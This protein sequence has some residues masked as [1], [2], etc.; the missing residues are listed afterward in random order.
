MAREVLI[1]ESDK[2][3]QNELKRIFEPAGYHLFF[4]SNDE[5]ALVRGRL[6]KPDLVIGG[7]GLCERMK[8]EEGLA[9]IP[10][11]LL[12]DPFEELSEPERRFLKPEGVIT[13]PF[14]EE[15]VQHLIG[16]LS[17]KIDQEGFSLEESWESDE[18]IIE[19]VDV[20]EEPE[21]KMSIEDLA[22]QT[23]EEPLGEMPAI[24]TW[25][26]SQK[27]AQETPKEFEMVLE[28]GGRQ[29]EETSEPIGRAAGLQGPEEI[30]LFQRI[31]MEEVM[32][33]VEQ[34]RP[35]LEKELGMEG[36]HTRP[37][38]PTPST[39]LPDP[40]SLLQEFETTLQAEEAVSSF[41]YREEQQE[42]LAP[43]PAETVELASSELQELGEDEFPEAF[44]EE[45]TDELEKL[46]EV[47]E[48][49]VVAEEE[50]GALEEFEQEF[51]EEFQEEFEEEFEEKFEEETK[52][53]ILPPQ[54]RFEEALEREFTLLQEISPTSEEFPSAE[55]LTPVEPFEEALIQAPKEKEEPPEMALERI[56]APEKRF[57]RAIEEVVVKGVQEMMQDFM[58]KVIPEI[59]TQVITHTMERI[60][61]L[62]REIVPELAE[63]AIRQEI[64]RLQKMDEG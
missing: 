10:F 45:L 25:E 22:L 21:S 64:E 14:S 17:E 2:G 58:G 35:T 54:P 19:L 63:K 34:L 41:S 31:D 13:R 60:E 16:Q 7:K 18:E 57:E 12:L 30:D 33:K 38:A 3:V 46:E 20:I 28:G 39:K 42:A 37:E 6:L 24:E 49:A 50:V 29:E 61:Q 59:A 11:I 44:L 53:E 47:E 51:P 40:Y 26:S 9:R 52:E 36:A 5:E 32:Q 27:E 15:A 55:A 48:E 8:T 62:V 4:T 43:T 23:E 1:A 56:P